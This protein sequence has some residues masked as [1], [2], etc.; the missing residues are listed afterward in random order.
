MA[1]NMLDDSAL[2]LSESGTAEPVQII[3]TSKNVLP[4]CPVHQK[5]ALRRPKSERPQNNKQIVWRNILIFL[6]LHTAAVYGLYLWCTVAMWKSILFSKYF[7][8][9]NECDYV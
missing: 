5:P 8:F 2:F 9:I 6:F 1:L 3:G 4:V 7:F